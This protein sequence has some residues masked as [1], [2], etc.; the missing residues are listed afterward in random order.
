MEIR[1]GSLDYP[2]K[3][4]LQKNLEDQGYTVKW[5]RKDMVVRYETPYRV[6]VQA[7]LGSK[8]SEIRRACGYGEKTGGGTPDSSLHRG[9]GGMINPE[10]VF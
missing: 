3:S 4:G 10:G 7:G 6:R 2:S 9:A 8:K 1:R 5:S